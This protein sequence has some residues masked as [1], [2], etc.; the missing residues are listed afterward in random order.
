MWL[1]LEALPKPRDG[2]IERDAGD[3]GNANPAYRGQLDAGNLRAGERF[4]VE[5]RAIHVAPVVTRKSI[6]EVG[7]VP[8]RRATRRERGDDQAE[9]DLLRGSWT[10]P[11]QLAPIVRDEWCRDATPGAGRCLQ[12]SWY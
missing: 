8:W 2:F 4:P 9:E 10:A 3:I 11:V 12:R 6:G 1:A 5:P 7:C